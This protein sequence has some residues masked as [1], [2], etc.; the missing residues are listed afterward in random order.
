MRF[1]RAA[2]ANAIKFTLPGPMTMVD[3]LY[4]EHYGSREKLAF[5]FAAILSEEKRWLSALG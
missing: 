3:T 5:A 1:L 2:T 4:D